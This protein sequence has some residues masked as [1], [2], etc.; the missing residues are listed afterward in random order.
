MNTFF[1]RHNNTVAPYVLNEKKVTFNELTFVIKGKLEYVVNGKPYSISEGDAVYI[2]AGS[3][4]QRISTELCDYVSFNFYYEID[5]NLPIA[6][7]DCI[8]EE[9]LC[10]FTACDQIYS[11]YSDWFDKI[12]LLRITAVKLI[13]SNIKSKSEKPIISQVTN[14][15]RNNLSQKITLKELASMVRYSPNY[16][17]TLFKK[18]I[19]I[20]L[21]SYIIRER[22]NYAKRLID[23]NILSLRNIAETVGISDY[24]YFCRMFKKITGQSPS[25]YSTTIQGK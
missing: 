16:L 22:I 7:K 6:I 14:Y 20:S 3:I 10:I 21:V 9:M 5:E 24:N 4:R 1:Y 13:L 11:K 23:E 15:I 12:D 8:G 18:T 2:K 25:G 17:D 19:G